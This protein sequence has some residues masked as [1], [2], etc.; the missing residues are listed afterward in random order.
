MRISRCLTLGALL[1]LTV[2]TAQAGIIDFT[3]ALWQKKVSGDNSSSKTRTVEGIDVTVTAYK[4]GKLANLT[5]TNFDGSSHAPCDTLLA[6]ETDGTGINDDEISYGAGNKTDVERIV[7]TF[8]QAL[9]ITKLHFFDLFLEGGSSGDP[10]VEKAQWQING[11]GVG[12]TLD[13]YL[14]SGYAETGLLDYT[15]VFQIEFFADTAKTASS[16]NSDFAV[17]G[18]SFASV[19]EPATFALLGLGLAGLVLRRKAQ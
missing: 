12:G 15:G 7:I 3:D 18:I 16:A 1:S 9:D 2:G 5:F 10:A 11:S 8:S 14:D 19:P 6:C 4:A 17:A 13:G